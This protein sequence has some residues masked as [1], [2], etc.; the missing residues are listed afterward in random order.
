MLADRCREHRHVA[1]Q[2]LDRREPEA[3][4]VRRHEH[5]V[6]GV[7]PQRQ[8]LRRRST[9]RDELGAAA[10]RDQLSPV[11]ALLGTQAVG[12]KEQQ[13]TVRVESDPL[14][15]GAAVD[16]CE[17]SRVDAAGKKQRARSRAAGRQ[18]RGEFGGR[19]GQYVE[20]RQHG[21]RRQPR[22]GDPHVAAVN[23]EGADARAHRERR[24]RREPV[25]GVHDVEV[26]A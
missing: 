19:R 25:V 5:G 14:P 16:R 9:E 6:G 24:P 17:A 21:R 4:A 12:G 10:E 2:S 23:G 8:L 13:R 1:G 22:A 20:R 11:K 7:D 26:P 18:L 3:L 15:R